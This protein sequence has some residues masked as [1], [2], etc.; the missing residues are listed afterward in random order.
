MPKNENK[1]K[2]VLA[3]SSPRRE[4]IL[5]QLRL[6][7][8][9]VPGKIDESKF[10]EKDPEKLVKK[11]AL[12][13]AK[14][15]SDLVEDAL[16]IAADTV[17]I[18]EDQILGKPEDSQEAKEQLKLLRGKE[19]Q[20]MTAVA[21]LSSDT[22]EVQVK[23]N[24][25]IVKMSNIS[26]ETIDKYINTGEPLDKAGS[27]GIQ[28]LG[29]LFVEGIKGSYYSVVGLPIHQLAEILDKFNYGIL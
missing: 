19:H 17:V 10:I 21:V 28:G 27:Y 20:V 18:C 14:S 5:K 22:G 4:D 6:R 16:I 2:L 15:V 25:T 12:E 13:K 26:D 23:N 3:S 11:L 24:I 9:I 29:G 7:F 8:T 1:Y